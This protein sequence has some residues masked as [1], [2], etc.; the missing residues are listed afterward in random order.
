[1][2]VKLYQYHR[3]AVVFCKDFAEVVRKTRRNE[4]F[5]P[6][7]SLVNVEGGFYVIDNG[8]VTLFT[9]P[10][11]RLIDAM[12]AKGYTVTSYVRLSDLYGY[13]PIEDPFWASVAAAISQEV[14][15]KLFPTSLAS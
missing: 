8:C 2:V 13:I 15:R 7:I 5:V 12:V 10:S 11:Y 6:E 4:I 3:T 9:P 1:M 14:I